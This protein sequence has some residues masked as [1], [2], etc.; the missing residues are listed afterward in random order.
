MNIQKRN[1]FSLIELII[2]V[3]IIGIMAGIAYPFYLN[4]VTQAKRSDAHTGLTR[5]A[6]EMEKY[7]TECSRY[8]TFYAAP[9]AQRDC[10]APGAIVANSTSPEGYYNLI[11]SPCAGGTIATCYSLSANPVGAQAANDSAKCGAITITNTGAKTATGT[12]GN[13]K[14][15]GKKEP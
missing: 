10:V 15:W 1:G 6:A 3:T 8:T 12:E 4:Y 5:L 11:I 9:G 7:F 14:C 13:N 2:A